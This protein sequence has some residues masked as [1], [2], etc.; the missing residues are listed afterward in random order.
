MK[1][2]IV[3]DSSVD[4]S[5]ELIEKYNIDVMPFYVLMN[6]KDLLDTIEIKP[7]DIIE[8]YNINK[9]LPKTSAI[10]I[11]RF[12]NKFKELTDEGYKVICFTIGS[13]ISGTYNN[14]V[15]ASRDFKG[16]EIIDGQSLS[17]G[18]ALLVLYAA[19]LIEK[20]VEFQEIVSK[21]KNRVNS[22]QASFVIDKLTFLHKG[23]RC[24]SLALLGANLLQIKPCIELNGGK[25]AVARKYRGPLKRVCETYVKE[26]LQK[27]NT[28]DLTRCFI[29]YSVISDEILNLVKQVLQENANFNEILI[30]Q[31]GATVTAH[32]GENTIGILYLNDGDKNGNF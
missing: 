29:T 15:V 23:G 22:I 14:A 16:V 20:G 26:T 9:T 28:P 12:A 21:V 17:T 6:D 18:T 7:E 27:F 1:I 19:D 11:D 8:N 4:L 5:K 2:K 24:S 3:T 10:S 13:G 31:A 25:M 30:A 32:C